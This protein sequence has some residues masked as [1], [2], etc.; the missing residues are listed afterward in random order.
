[1]DIREKIQE[2]VDEAGISI[3]EL[4]E[5]SGV[6]R[7]SIMNFLKGGNIHLKNLEKLLAALGYALE[8]TKLEGRPD[9]TLLRERI[10]VSKEKLKEFCSRN[11]IEYL[12]VFG[13]VLRD[14]FRDDSDI[15]V[16]VRLESDVS[17]FELMDIEE[18]LKGVFGTDH[19]IDLVTEQALSPLIREEIG[20]AYEVLY[21]KVA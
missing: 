17:F 9:P 10:E 2:M 15:D 16:L 12:A 13:S 18:E 7:A 1:M 11:N 20:S 19:K 8:P 4:S 3:R 6:R 14:D 5:K 21:E